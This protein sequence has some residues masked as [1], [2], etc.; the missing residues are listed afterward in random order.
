MV[1]YTNGRRFAC[2]RQ[3]VSLIEEPSHYGFHVEK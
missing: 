3:L 2:E 1:V